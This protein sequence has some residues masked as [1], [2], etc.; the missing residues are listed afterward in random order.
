MKLRARSLG[1]PVVLIAAALFIVSCGREAP[2][3][4]QP[5]PDADLAGDLDQAVGGLLSCTPQPYATASAT[6]GPEG[7]YL[8]VGSNVFIVPE[9]ALSAPV[10]I[11][12]TAPSGTARV[13]N[14]QPQGLQFARPAYLTMSFSG[15]SL[16]ASLLPRIAYV[17]N[18]LTILS[19]IPSLASLWTRT[20][21]GQVSH[22]S[23]YAIAY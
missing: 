12:A 20:V 18:S 8:T 19:Y 3:A 14:F 15:C 4:A 10:T 2:T 7:G 9:G 11:T 13:V 6:I 16:L 1:R 21:T 22:F 5:Q 23:G 17:D